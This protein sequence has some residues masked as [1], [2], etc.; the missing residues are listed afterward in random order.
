MVRDAF[1]ELE[2]A[3]GFRRVFTTTMEV[4]NR[5]ASPSN[6]GDSAHAADGGYQLNFVRSAIQ[7]SRE[8]LAAGKG[9]QTLGLI[10]AGAGGLSA[11]GP[12]ITAA[13]WRAS[14]KSILVTVSHDAG[15][16]LTLPDAVVQRGLGFTMRTGW[17]GP[18]SRGTLVYAT[19]AVKESATTI[20]VFF[21][22]PNATLPNNSRLFYA[23]QG[24]N[25]SLA[26]QLGGTGS[27]LGRLGS[28]RAVRDNA[29]ACTV[30]ALPIAADLGPAFQ[31]DMPLQWTPAGVAI[32]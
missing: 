10:P 2:T 20:R 25:Y 27:G 23:E 29:S 24:N 15:T 31:P 12:R 9:D 30:A 3:D 4:D 8:I 13:Q 6:F 21:S 26:P 16:D 28:G 14:D 5:A 1:A 7:I 32:S 11:F 19:S 22:A 17:T 18:S